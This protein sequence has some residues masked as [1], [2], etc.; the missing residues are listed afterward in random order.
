MKLK[1]G[2]ITDAGQRNDQLNNADVIVL[3]ARKKVLWKTNLGVVAN[4]SVR[5]KVGTP[6]TTQ[7]G[8]KEFWCESQVCPHREARRA[9]D[10]GGACFFRQQEHRPR[11][12]GRPETHPGLGGQ[13]RSRHHGAARRVQVRARPQ[14]LR[15]SRTSSLA[16]WWTSARRWIRRDAWSGTFRAGS[17]LI[18]RFGHTAQGAKTHASTPAGAGY[19]VDPLSSEA[20]DL[21]FAALARKM[22]ED[23]GPQA[24]KVLRSFFIDSYEAG[25]VNWTSRFRRRISAASRI[26]SVAVSSG[27][28]RKNCSE[29]RCVRAFPLGLPPHHRRPVCGQLLR[30]DR[31]ASPGTGLG[32]EAEAYGGYFDMLQAF[33]RTDIPWGE[34]WSSPAGLPDALPLCQTPMDASTKACGVRGP[35]LRQARDQV[36]ELHLLRQMADLSIPSES[37]RRP[38]VLRGDQPDLLGGVRHQPKFDDKPGVC[39]YW[40][41]ILD[42]NTT[43]WAQSHAWHDYLARCSFL[44]QQG[45]YV[46]DVCCFR[47]E[48][49]SLFAVPRTGADPGSATVT[50]SATPRCS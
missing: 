46:A 6:A 50:M 41:P 10:R 24:G 38:C 33:G 8:A 29:W 27:V 13:G 48:G 5:L 23:A 30:S 17:W 36:G 39:P 31:R 47:G 3:D 11:K 18:L 32:F 40:G 9:F 44:L 49:V 28:V 19:E 7:A 37:L 15:A 34:F 42:R 22:I 12:T 21:H 43:W 35:Y 4:P 26:R 45:L 16:R 14:R 2:E 20:L 1:S 25:A